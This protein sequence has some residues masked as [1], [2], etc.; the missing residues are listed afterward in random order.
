MPVIDIPLSA[1]ADACTAG[2]KAIWAILNANAY[3]SSLV[4]RRND[5][6]D[7]KQKQPLSAVQTADLPEVSLVQGAFDL[8]PWGGISREAEISQTYTLVD[9]TDTLQVAQTNAIKR[10]VMAAFRHNPP[11]QVTWNGAEFC[12]GFLLSNGS[13]AA[14]NYPLPGTDATAGR[15]VFRLCSIVA[16]RLELYEFA[17]NL[18]A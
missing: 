16:I 10:G 6:S 8:K 5:W 11:E 14:M 15:G 12:R 17:A 7:G 4:R 2:Y 9:V 13:D 18:P 1:A 3:F